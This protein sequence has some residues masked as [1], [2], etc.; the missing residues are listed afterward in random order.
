MVN[1]QKIRSMAVSL[2]NLASEFK[3]EQEF[4]AAEV[5][6]ALEAILEQYVETEKKFDSTYPAKDIS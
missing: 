3:G 1:I 6:S 5:L 2:G 4:K